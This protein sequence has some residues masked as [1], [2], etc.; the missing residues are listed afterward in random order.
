MNRELIR[1][2]AYLQNAPAGKR[3]L[4]QLASDIPAEDKLQIALYARFLP[5][6]NTKQKLDLLK[7]YET[8]RITKGGHS[9]EGY[10]DAVSRDFFVGLTEEEAFRRLRRSSMDTQR[11]LADTARAVLGAEVV[12]ASV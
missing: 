6:L 10:I 8:A 2:V 7:Y 4:E 12:A 9:F 3:M 11:P 1:L 5:D